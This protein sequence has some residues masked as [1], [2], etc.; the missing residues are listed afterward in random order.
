MVPEYPRYENH[1]GHS[2]SSPIILKYPEMIW[3]ICRIAAFI[4]LS[5]SSVVHCGDS[6]PDHQLRKYLFGCQALDSGWKA[7]DYPLLVGSYVFEHLWLGS[8][9]FVVNCAKDFGSL[10]E[11]RNI[12]DQNKWRWTISGSQSLPKSSRRRSNR[13]TNNHC[14]KNNAIKILNYICIIKLYLI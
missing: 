2:W 1:H 12:D 3:L 8:K 10:Y 6:R 4:I 13:N 11:S 5:A 14:K 7:L 9:C